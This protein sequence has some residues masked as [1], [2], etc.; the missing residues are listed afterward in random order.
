MPMN[1]RHSLSTHLVLV[2]L[3][4]LAVLLVVTTLVETRLERQF[5][6]G[7]A[8]TAAMNLSDS[9]AEELQGILRSTKAATRSGWASA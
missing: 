4:P 2:I 8:E 7:T 1:K 3:V 6:L 5:I 9:V